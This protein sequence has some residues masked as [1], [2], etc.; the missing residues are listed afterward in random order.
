ME[1]KM[2]YFQIA[3]LISFLN[4]AEAICNSKDYLATTSPTSVE[5]LNY[6]SNE[7]CVFNIMPANQSSH[8]LEITIQKFG[9]Q[10]KMPECQGDFMEIFIT[11]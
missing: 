6:G 11:R 8:Y 7:D 1:G 2:V 5:H 10:A 9:I 3:F 4:F